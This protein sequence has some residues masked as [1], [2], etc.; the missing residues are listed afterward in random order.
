MRKKQVPAAVAP[1][2]FQAHQGFVS[3]LTSNPSTSLEAAL[4]L[5]TC[6]FNRSAAQGLAALFG[7]P[8]IQSVAMAAKVFQLPL[9]FNAAPGAQTL[10][11]LFE[12]RDDF[13]RS[14]GF[15]FL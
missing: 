5:P 13:D 1:E 7:A 8:I 9:G 11:G 14:A 15:E 2:G 4:I 3:G 6:R 12:F 10:G